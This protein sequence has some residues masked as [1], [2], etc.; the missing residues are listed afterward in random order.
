MLPASTAL[1]TTTLSEMLRLTE[2][3]VAARTLRR[4]CSEH[5]QLQV[6][7]HQEQKQEPAQGFAARCHPTT[8]SSLPSRPPTI[9]SV[10]SRNLSLNKPL[11]PLPR[12][13]VQQS[14]PKPSATP[15]LRWSTN[16]PVSEAA[17]RPSSVDLY[18][19]LQQGP[20]ERRR[21]RKVCEKMSWKGKMKRAGRKVMAAMVLCRRDDQKTPAG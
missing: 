9:S 21:R 10:P 1:F 4:Y 14:S 15:T 16:L 20:G 13:V 11:P 7:D 12:R 17:L 6:P 19:K 2:P 3:T 5:L 8:L 18:R